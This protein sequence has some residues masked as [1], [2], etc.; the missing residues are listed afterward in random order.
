M[1]SSLVVDILTEAVGNSH[2]VL[3]FSRRDPK[4]SCEKQFKWSFYPSGRTAG[5]KVW[6]LGRW[7][8]WH[9][10]S[11]AWSNDKDHFVLYFQLE[12]KYWWALVTRNLCSLLR[13]FVYFPLHLMNSM[14]KSNLGRKK[15]KKI[16]L[17]DPS[18]LFSLSLSK[19]TNKLTSKTTTNKQKNPLCLDKV[20]ILQWVQ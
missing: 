11:H 1:Y 2:S 5:Q 15:G 9:V 6:G 10:L 8:L 14:F 3:S 12:K 7:C 4:R 18:I 16:L 19:Q 20:H 13:N 17:P